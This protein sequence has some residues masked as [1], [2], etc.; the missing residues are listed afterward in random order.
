M[1]VARFTLKLSSSTFAVAA[2][3]A[4]ATPANAAQAPEQPV[5]ASSNGGQLQDQAGKPSGGSAEASSTAPYGGEI[6]ITAQRRAENLQKVP[7]TINAVNGQALTNAGILDTENLQAVIPGLVVNNIG[8]N[9][10]IYLRGVGSRAANAGL[11]PSTATYQDDRYIA[12]SQGNLFE[13]MDVERVEVVKGPQGVLFGRNATAGAIRVITNDVQSDFGGYAQASYGN[14]NEYQLR[15]TLNVPF[16]PFAGMRL[17]AMTHHRDG[18]EKN[19]VD[20]GRSRM[21]DE[22]ISAIR[23]KFKAE[24]TSN[25][26]LHLTVDASREDDSN[27]LATVVLPPYE[28]STLTATGA[29][30]GKKRGEFASAISSKQKQRT[31]GSEFRADFDV[32]FADFASITTYAKN[33]TGYPMDYDGTNV[34]ATDINKLEARNRTFTQEVQLVSKGNDRLEWL[35]GANYYD[36]KASIETILDT[37]IGRLTPNGHQTAWTKSYAAFGQL[38]WHLNDQFALIGGGRFTDDNIRV[39]LDQVPGVINALPLNLLPFRDKVSFKKFTPKAAIQW[40]IDSERMVYASYSRGF[41]S[42]GFSNPATPPNVI[43]EPEV[44]DNYEV[45]LK[46]TAGRSLSFALSAF[47]YDYKNLQVSSSVIAN[48]VPITLT[49][50][51]ADASVKGAELEATYRPLSNLNFSAAVSYL[52]GRYDNYPSAIAPFYRADTANPG[53][54]LG[55]VTGVSID[56]SGRRMLRM[57][58]W[59]G[60][61]TANYQAPVRGGSLEASATY[62]FKSSYDFDF[63]ETPNTRNLRQP[64]FGLLSGTIGYRLDAGDW[65]LSAYGTNLLNAKYFV[66]RQAGSTGVIATFGEPRTYGL[67]LEKSF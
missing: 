43:V 28:L 55:M 32:G 51:A 48:G 9:S 65:K 52:H 10:S 25:I 16:S 39:L 60:S 27:N 33:R 14:Y 53:N 50:N 7:L 40:N 4:T 11:E 41:K 15:G 45:G 5:Q 37:P 12:G 57:P 22:E 8:A 23:A 20:T 63:V 44:L 21:N 29:I 36:N 13:L 35:V 26:V 34:V 46:G 66:F 18:F 17:S 38:T 2:S 67:R 19:L 30:T 31:F 58:Q 62:S 24:P 42:G 6:V 64:G 56:A 1:N 59:S 54:G 61:V 49:T 3:I 47:Y